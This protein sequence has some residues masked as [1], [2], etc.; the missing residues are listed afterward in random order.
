MCLLLGLR[1]GIAFGQVE[2][3][4]AHSAA[5]HATSSAD[6]NGVINVQ[7]KDLLQ[8]PVAENWSKSFC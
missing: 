2:K 5:P 6:A 7:Q 8:K 1:A 4:R 3:A